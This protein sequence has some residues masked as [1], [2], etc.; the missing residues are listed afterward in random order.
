MNDVVDTVVVQQG[1]PD[2]VVSSP[3]DSVDVAVAERE[4][5]VV[6]QSDGIGSVVSQSNESPVVSGEKETTVVSAGQLGPVGPRGPAGNDT[7]ER[8][9]AGPM[10]ALRIVW[11][12]GNGIVR[13]LGQSDVDHV[14]LISGLTLTAT[15]S[16]G[17]VTIKRS[18]PV[19]D[20]A[21]S[22]ATS[23]PIWLGESGQL[24]QVPPA[25]GFDVRIGHAVSP[26][27]IYLDIQSPINLE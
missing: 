4:T 22:W 5:T 13:E 6:A 27:R 26:T 9:T 18:G 10:S 2:V 12:D 14:N 20:A 11:E 8:G 23:G 1:G 16:S 25:A 15:G 7:F 24:T 21:W 19:D 3:D 17:T